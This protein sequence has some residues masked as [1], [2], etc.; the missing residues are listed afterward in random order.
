MTPSRQTIR[1][2]EQLPA[3]LGRIRL[4]LESE[5]IPKSGA[6]LICQN[7]VRTNLQN[8]H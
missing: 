2:L 6:E 3:A 8:N 1:S 4:K 5:G 7:A